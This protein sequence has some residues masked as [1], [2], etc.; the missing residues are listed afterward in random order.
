MVGQGTSSSGGIGSVWIEKEVPSETKKW[1]FVWG[2]RQGLNVHA[3]DEAESDTNLVVYTRISTGELAKDPAGQWRGFICGVA[4]RCALHVTSSIRRHG[5]RN[6]HYSND[7]CDE[8][9]GTEL[10]DLVIGTEK[11]ATVLKGMEQLD[12]EERQILADRFWGDQTL[13]SIA[14]ARG[15]SLSGVHGK[16]RKGLHRLQK[17][18]A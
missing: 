1:A 16:L 8:T 10:D 7:S 15:I 2:V 12:L 3:I 6:C 18:L 13:K 17:I 9:I 5:S 4:R 14:T 11:L